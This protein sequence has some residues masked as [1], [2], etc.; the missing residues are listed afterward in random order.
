MF[1]K[2]V[3]FA[4]RATGWTGADCF[5][6]AR[7]VVAIVAVAGALA[8]LPIQSPRAD[9]P[10]S[11]PAVAAPSRA[12]AAADASR[13]VQSYATGTE[14]K[15]IVRWTA[16]ICVQ[17]VGLAPTQ[18]AA[19]KARIEAV[20]QP[21]GRLGSSC[22]IPNASV[23]FTNNGQRTLDEIAARNRRFLGD[24]G[25]D[26]TTVKTVTRPIQAW[27]QTSRCFDICVVVGALV[28]V[29][30]SRTGDTTLAA[31]TDD[32]AMLVL[33]E[34]RNPDRCRPLPSVTDLFAGPCPG[35]AVPTG[36]TR[37]DLAYLKAVYSA[38]RPLTGGV[39]GATP[40]EAPSLDQVAGRMGA[41]LAGAAPLPAPGAVPLL[42]P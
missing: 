34:P 25:S 18:A 37:S 38:D 7:D 26:T 29:D 20:G 41:L 22:T 30:L 15:F 17:V 4:V 31:I 28:L 5:P 21:L 32:A 42:H 19:V 40:W 27:Y 3:M 9:T 16:H 2:F 11:A 10:T 39:E 8:A 33:S 6:A 14:R 1:A 24:G 12:E 35:R 23:V 36:L 13:F